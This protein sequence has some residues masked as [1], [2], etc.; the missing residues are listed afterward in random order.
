MMKRII[1]GHEIEDG[2]FYEIENTGR[3]KIKHY[4]CTEAE[5]WAEMDRVHQILE[6]CCA[7]NR[8]EMTFVK[9]VQKY[10]K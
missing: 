3:Q 10:R 1:C 8:G 6:D 7:V 9:F 2:K 5:H 4:V